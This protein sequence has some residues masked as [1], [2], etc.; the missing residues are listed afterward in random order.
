[1][2]GEATYVR[3]LHFRRKLRERGLAATRPKPRQNEQYP[4]KVDSTAHPDKKRQRKWKIVCKSMRQ[5]RIL[6]ES[7]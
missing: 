3:G 2:F 7:L 4:W 1:M 5:A 6:K